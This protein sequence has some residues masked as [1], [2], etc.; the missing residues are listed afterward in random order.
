MSPYDLL[1][2]LLVLATVITLLRAGWFALRRQF[3][4]SR[5]LLGKIAIGFAIYMLIVVGASLILPQRFLKPENPVC[6]D[7][8]CMAITGVERLPRSGHI[9]YDVRLRLSS[10]A[11]R[12]SQRENHLDVYLTDDQAKR[13]DP[14]A[15][16]LAHPLN[17]LLGPGESVMAS[18]SFIVPADATIRG[19]VIK[20]EGGFPIDWFII[21]YSTW[22][23][24]PTVIEFGA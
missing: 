13:Y 18:R 16:S 4:R 20:H 10:R 17:V 3:G 15:E 23:R 1:F 11:R 22:F 19:L 21:G 5:R 7:D 6:F 9:A 24:K 8:W 14:T 12:V 2:L